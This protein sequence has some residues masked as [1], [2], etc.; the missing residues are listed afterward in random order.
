MNQKRVLLQVTVMTLSLLLSVGCNISQ[1]TPTPLPPTPTSIPT[2]S[3]TPLP[4]TAVPTP[5]PASIPGIDEPI[6]VKN[7]SVKDSFGMTATG[8]LE[9]QSLD[10]YAQESLEGGDAGPIHP[11]DTS[12]VFLTLLLDLDGPSNSVNWVA[13]NTAFACGGVEY[14][15]ER[16]GLKVGEGGILA[17]WLLIYT[18]PGDTDFGGC[19][20][21]LPDEQEIALTSFFE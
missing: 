18:V 21:Q 10:A 3:A 2:P 12:N 11:D 17:G 13:L 6:V 20:L 16:T 15:A 1:P 7:I 5:T 9:I 4:P 14:Q 8:D 19:T